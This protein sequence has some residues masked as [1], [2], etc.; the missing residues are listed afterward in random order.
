[1]TTLFRRTKRATGVAVAVV[2]LVAGVAALLSGGPDGNLL[3]ASALVLAAGYGAAV[4]VG[5]F[6][7]RNPQAVAYLVLG[8]GGLLIVLSAVTTVQWIVVV[9]ALLLVGAGG[10]LYYAGR[11]RGEEA[12]DAENGD[13]TPAG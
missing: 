6:T 13:G 10:A 11:P 5:L 4:L 3:T 9:G 12:T 2:G 1:M 8:A 7:A